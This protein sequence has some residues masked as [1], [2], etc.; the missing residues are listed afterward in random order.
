M[1]QIEVFVIW[2]SFTLINR[3]VPKKA[4]V[5]QNFLKMNYPVSELRRL[6]FRSLVS[7]FSLEF[8]DKRI[9]KGEM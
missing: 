5:D 8:I 3:Q 7:V 2:V 1:V 6:I 4:H 9:P